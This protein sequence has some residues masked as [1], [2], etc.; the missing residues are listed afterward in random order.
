MTTAREMEMRPAA[1]A[2]DVT[3]LRADFPVLQQPVHGRPLVYLD[4]GATS[5]KPKAVIEAVSRFYQNDYANVHRG[6]H[7]L[8]E[9]ATRRYEQARDRVRDFIGA[10]DS[11]EI[12]FV[13]GTT[14]AINLVADSYGR[15]FGP[16]DQ[17]LITA[18]E[19]HA[20]I[21]PWQLICQRTGAELVV[22]PVDDAGDLRMAE[23]D[24]L[25][26]DR[27]RMVAV[28]HVSN[29][30]GTVNPVRRITELAHRYG[31]M[32][33]VDA[34][35]SVP[36]F[37][38]DVRQLDC[39]FLA[40][41]AHKLYGPTGIGVLY[42]RAELL[43]AMP[44]YQG[45][46]EMIREVRFEGTTYA[47]IP[48]KFEAGTP[49]IAGAIGLAA[50]IDYLHGVGL[51]HIVRH[52]Q[53]LLEYATGQLS[54]VPG[55]RIIGTA[56]EKA[57]MVSFVLD[58]VHAHD[59]GTILD[60]QGVAVRVGHHCAMPIMRR[61]GVPATARAAFALYNTRSDIDALVDAVYKVK[62]VFGHV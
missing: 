15:Q 26:N 43:R 2:L 58:G 28:S 62:E 48:C 38:V 17:I 45:G 54:R 13:R 51:E 29:A 40:F 10:A 33:L 42:G 37:A 18:M 8:S 12:V 16:G 5:Q 60:R 1:P 55:L 44:P 4:N 20:N 35:Q 47:D 24:G 30:L 23:F 36:H 27:T 46:G 53:D 7:A 11:R 59:I 41:S 19:H 39:D 6:V 52:E 3:R 56:R 49:H 21:V 22:A 32:V 25:L 14:E 34:A 57:G 9:R 50:A 31:A 61:F